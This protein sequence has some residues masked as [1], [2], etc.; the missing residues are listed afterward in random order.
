MKSWP[1]QDFLYI[2][3]LTKPELLC[4]DYFFENGKICFLFLT[5]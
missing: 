5:E 4:R 2:A 1:V 3:T